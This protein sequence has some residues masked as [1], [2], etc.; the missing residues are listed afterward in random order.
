MPYN[1]QELMPQPLLAE[2]RTSGADKVVQPTS[3][4]PLRNCLFEYPSGA[5]LIKTCSGTWRAGDDGDGSLT[6]E[7]SI[8]EIDGNKASHATQARAA[9]D[10][11][12][13]GPQFSTLFARLPAR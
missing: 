5:E 4:C 6:L 2:A 3:S 7:F 9:K 13:L 11:F 1:Q 8:T 10:G 12:Y